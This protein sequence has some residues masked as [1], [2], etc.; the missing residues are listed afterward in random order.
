LSYLEHAHTRH[1]NGKQD[2]TFSLVGGENDFFNNIYISKLC[3][4]VL[5]YSSVLHFLDNNCDLMT[6]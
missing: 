3:T 1:V 6:D 4:F 2:R 5:I